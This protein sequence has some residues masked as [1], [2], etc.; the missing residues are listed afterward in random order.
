MNEVGGDPGSDG[1]SVEEFHA[2]NAK[3]QA[4]HPLTMTTL[5]THDT[6]RSDDVRARLAVLTEMPGRVWRGAASLVAHECRAA[7]HTRGWKLDC[8]SQHRVLLLPDADRGM[9]YLTRAAEGL[10][11]EGGAR[12]EAADLVGREQSRSLKMR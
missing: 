3:M 4:T 11:A 9:A 2:Y 10:H 8:G 5:S 12:G 1:M 6:K 7:W